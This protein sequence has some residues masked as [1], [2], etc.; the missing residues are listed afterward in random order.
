M[1]LCTAL[2]LMTAYDTKLY[3]LHSTRSRTY[4]EE[5]LRLGLRY[6]DHPVRM[7]ISENPVDFLPILED[8]LPKLK[9]RAL[10]LGIKWDQLTVS[11]RDVLIGGFG[12]ASATIPMLCFTEALEE[13]SLFNH[14]FLFGAYGL[15]VSRHWIEQHGGDRV[16]YV[17]ENSAVTR[18][19]QRMITSLKLSSLFVQS[20]Q[21]LFSLNADELIWEILQYVQVRKN[22]TEFEWRIPGKHGLFGGSRSTDTR[23]PIELN[24][25]HGILVQNAEDVPYFKELLTELAIAQNSNH[26]PLVEM[27]PNS[28]G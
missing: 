11:Q 3:F 15:L 13:R 5:A 17:G 1:L 23:L 25:I 8:L 22:L 28:I 19:L 18:A 21:L 16:V 12:S 14:N 10:Y 2:L 6:S 9:E 27:Q 26:V 20:G 4:L 24:D 7:R